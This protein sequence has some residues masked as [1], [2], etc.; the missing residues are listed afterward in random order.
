MYS[1]EPLPQQHVLRTLPNVVLTPHLGYFT[2]EMLT[3][4]Y[5]YAIE[6]IAAF[7]DGKPIR[8]VR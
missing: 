3:A 5:T 2:R 7:L 1:V 4:Y 8:V 6:N